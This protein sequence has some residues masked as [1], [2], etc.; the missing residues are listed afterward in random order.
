MSKSIGID[1]GTTNSVFAI[2]KI[3]TEILKNAE[4]DLIT[5]SCVTL[6]T[7]KLPVSKPEFI[8]GKHALEWIKQKPQ[9]TV[10][11]IKRLIGRSF[12]DPEVQDMITDHRLSYQIKQQTKGT[13]NSL[14]IVLNDQ[15]YTPE[16]ISAKILEKCRFD[17]E[18]SLND[19]V[20]Y[21]VIT[22]PAYFN[23]KQKHAT[24][25]AAVLAGLKVRRLLPEPTAAAI[26]FGVDNIKDDEAKTILVFDFGGG[27]FDLSVLTISGGQFIE[28]GKGGDM[29]LGGSEI[30]HLLAKHILKE[31]ANENQIDDISVLLE[32]QHEKQRNLFFGELQ[33]QVE[34]AKI[35]L[36]K[37][38]EACIEILG[39]LKDQDG[40]TIDIDIELTRDQFNDIIAPVIEA[41]VQL[42]SKTL[43]DLQFSPDLIDKV[44]LVGGS[45]KIPKIIEAMQQMFGV[46]KVMLHKRP[47][48]AIAEGAAILSHRL[49]ETYECPQ[50][51]HSVLQTANLCEKCGFDLD[52]YTVETGVWDIVHSSAH[53]YYIH[54]ENNERYLFVEQNTPLP[55]EKTETFKLVDL[56]QELVHM[57]FSNQVN[58]KEENIGDLWLGFDL[59]ELE[60]NEEVDP[61]SSLHVEVTLKIDENN[62]IEVSAALKE[63]PDIKLSKT[64]SRGK[65][66]E[67]LFLSLEKLI[68]EAN[69]LE[70][71]KYIMEDLLSR[72]L[73]A[74]KTIDKIVDP[75]NHKVDAIACDKAAM[76]IEKAQKLAADEQF[77][78]GAIT[79]A[80]S[81]LYDF[82]LAIS[83]EVK[84]E[85]RE[86][87]KHLREMD[88][89]GTYEEN[90]QAIDNLQETLDKL[91]I[92]QLLIEIQKAETICARTDQTKAYKFSQSLTD[93]TKA[94]VEQDSDK[95]SSL[96]D[97][98]MPEV[99]K[100]VSADEEKIFTI[101]KDIAIMP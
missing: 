37:E 40:D 43:E 96:L 85:I 51:G 89:H 65:A 44:L 57:R 1:L 48:L 21:V 28:Q 33:E 72:A 88:E 47:M 68:T 77:S 41:T 7:S 69:K 76:Q 87:V 8:V 46:E 99:N 100:I 97:E 84:D 9:N 6:K 82:D 38:D 23:D 16:E 22:V 61:E 66:D 4:G 90:N 52:A 92:V 20:E 14:A 34:K 60:E 63:F 70:Y 98:I 73:L 18:A 75:K 5:P 71:K 42:T 56:R 93:I 12:N 17:A 25:I 55:F 53:D 54:L 59:N 30:D 50:C 101:H 80:E 29:W 67:Q 36:S 19:N 49:A 94:I 2:K 26:S 13:Q 86:A 81:A 27:T 31:I 83:P 79:Y 78:Q 11:L 39:V 74:I 95:I 3:N 35:Q 15:E 64:L 32:K 10:T 45:S 24:R 91:G 58:G 62:L